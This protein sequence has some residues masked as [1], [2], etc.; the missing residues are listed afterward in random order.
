MSL[1]R[2]Q[3]L[4]K[5]SFLISPFKLIYGCP[6]LTPGISPKC[7]PLP[8]D[9]LN[10]LLCHFCFLQWNFADHHLPRPHTVP[11]PLPV[12][13][14]DQLLLSSPDNRRSPLSP[15]C[16]DPFKVILIT[17]TAAKFEGLYWVH[18]SHLKPFTL[19][20]KNDSSS[21]ASTL[22][23]S[24]SLKLQKTS[25]PPIL[26]PV[27]ENETSLQQLSSTPLD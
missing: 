6:V 5:G 4:L 27:S 23:G 16:Q 15:K 8:D 10:P 24:C 26:S 20:P 14:G 2:L 22:I 21:Y 1:F 17:P 19:P 13:I 12:N 9:L 18:L 11:C 7:S 25:R 3:G